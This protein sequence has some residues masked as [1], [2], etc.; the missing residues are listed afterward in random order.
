MVRLRGAND[1]LQFPRLPTRT[2][3]S[4]MVPTGEFNMIA[5]GS[6][7]LNRP[8]RVYESFYLYRI[9]RGPGFYDKRIVNQ[10]T[11]EKA[12]W[13]YAHLIGLKPTEFD[14]ECIQ[15]G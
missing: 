9:I 14:I 1:H 15:R 6:R 4:A 5:E 10:F 11:S 8:T 2:R 7:C 13:D 3:V 12:A